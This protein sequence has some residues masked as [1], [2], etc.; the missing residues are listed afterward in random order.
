MFIIE[1][2]GI[3]GRKKRLVAPSQLAEAEFRKVADQ[4]GRKAF[5]ARKLGLVAARRAV[6]TAIETRWDGKETTN[7][8]RPGDWIVTNLSPE[9]RVLRD[10][11][12]NENTYVVEAD[13]FPG[14]Y[15]PAGGQ[16]K[17][18]QIFKAKST[19]DALYLSGGFDILAPW[20]EKQTAREGYLLLNGK[21]VYGNNAKTFDAT[22]EVIH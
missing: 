9:A 14:L 10:N 13:T 12:G 21:D 1:S 20:G 19:V 7:T 6:E 3:F 17:F 11:E 15:E 18:G 8:A 2:A 16:S 4:I 5:K 22:Y